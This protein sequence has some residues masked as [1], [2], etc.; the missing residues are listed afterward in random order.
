MV[1]NLY[2]QRGVSG[3]SK[4]YCTVSQGPALPVRLLLMLQSSLN[5]SWKCLVSFVRFLRP[6]LAR[7]S[8]QPGL[9]PDGPASFIEP[10]KGSAP[11]SAI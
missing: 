7:L 6:A 5:T 2:G 9:Q 1:Y 10:C 4:C 8:A 3:L 11:G